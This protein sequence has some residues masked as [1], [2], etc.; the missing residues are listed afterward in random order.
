MEVRMKKGDILFII[1]IVFIAVLFFFFRG[2]F[3]HSIKPTNK[4]VQHLLI[5]SNNAQSSNSSKE[6]RY[7]LTLFLIKGI[8]MMVAQMM[9]MITRYRKLIE[10]NNI[11][12]LSF[13][14]LSQGRI[15]V[16]LL[17]D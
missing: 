16:Y 14:L 4:D 12:F 7:A 9:P 5:G 1:L 17:R 3:K 8:C 15:F 2:V 13:Y 10:A 6:L 11:I